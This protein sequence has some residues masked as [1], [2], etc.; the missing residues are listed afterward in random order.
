MLD[1]SVVIVSYNS[2]HF[3]QLCLDS[4]SSALDD[5][6]AEVIVVDN[7][8]SDDSCVL[9]K[10][11]YPW[12][13]LIENNDNIGF[14]RANNIAIRMAKGQH[15]LLLNPDTLVSKASIVSSMQLLDEDESNGAV[16]IKMIDGGGL[17][18]PESK[19][20]L[21]TPKVAFYKAFGLAKCFP[22]S[23]EF[24]RYYLGHLPN[25]QRAE[26]EVLAGAYMLIRTDVLMKCDG[27]DEAFFMYGE[28]IDL[29]Y[30]IS[31]LGYRILYN[32]EFPIVH[33]KGE[34]AGRDAAWTQ[35]FYDAMHLF[36]EKHFSNQ[37]TVLNLVINIGIKVRKQFAPTK[38]SEEQKTTLLGKAIIVVA[39]TEVELFKGISSDFSTLSYVRPDELSV[40]GGEFVLFS[41]SLDMSTVI[42]LMQKHAG[43]CQFFFSPSEQTFILT[44]PSSQSCGQVFS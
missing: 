17:F 31:K 42:T 27:F 10:S 20:G 18:L 32:P 36:S 26:V 3:I 1:L 2:R 19:R 39:N 15:T 38:A 13:T 28:D 16:G 21:P 44:S 14:G 22:H 8:S 24:A 33:F 41:P 29:S 12:V 37:G 25:D 40:K 23:P 5:I 11:K 30:R 7:Q 43:Q 4:L 34:S 35:R 9:I 6:K